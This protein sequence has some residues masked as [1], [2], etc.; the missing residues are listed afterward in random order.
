MRILLAALLVLSACERSADF[1]PA[2][3]PSSPPATATV[4][5]APPP[6]PPVVHEK[7]VNG[8]GFTIVLAEGWEL[9]GVE[10]GTLFSARKNGVGGFEIMRLADA[11]R[12]VVASERR[13]GAWSAKIAHGLSGAVDHSALVG[14]QCSAKLSAK[15]LM[16]HIEAHESPTG[17][18][19]SICT[20]DIAGDCAAMLASRKEDANARPMS[21]EHRITLG[22]ENEHPVARGKGFTVTF[23][24]DWKLTEGS[25]EILLQA[26]S[27]SGGVVSIVELEDTSFIERATCEADGKP[28][29]EALHGE[30]V[31]AAVVE[32]PIGFA[33]RIDMKGAIFGYILNIK[34]PDAKPYM[35]G[36]GAT[37]GD[38]P[39]AACT[40]IL[41]HWRFQ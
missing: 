7:R 24:D 26:S 36:C 20:G 28:M 4:H 27:A 41:E 31:H 21:L 9:Q 17:S 10:G 14:G 12:D 40:S 38:V 19:A 30:F 25:A 5:P 18:V 2:S 16:F 32:T 22:F 34:A 3:P 23:P 8:A 29:A 35:F 39:E 13:C 37:K 1:G 33:C 11:D 15:G 6:A